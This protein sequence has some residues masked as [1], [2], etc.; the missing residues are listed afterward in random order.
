M[1]Q[2]ST[3]DTRHISIFTSPGCIKVPI[4]PGSSDV[5]WTTTPITRIARQSR[6]FAEITQNCE[7][8]H[9]LEPNGSARSIIDWA[10]KALLDRGQCRAFEIMASTFVLSFYC[11]A[12]TVSRGQRVC[13]LFTSEKSRLKKL[14]KVRRCHSDQPTHLSALWPWWQWK[15]NCYRFDDGIC[16]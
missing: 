1:L 9:V 16:S 2:T 5:R 13:H 6:T 10:K 3:S 12:S 14:A 7:T 4:Y 11:S 8:V 15:N